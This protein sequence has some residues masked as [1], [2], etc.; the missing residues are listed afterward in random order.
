MAEPYYGEIR[1]FALGSY[2]PRNWAHCNGAILEISQND[3][4]F[5]VIGDMYGGNGRTTMALPNLQG[6]APMHPGTGPGLTPR[7]LTE[8]LGYPAIL[9]DE[10]NL[11][12]HT[13]QMVG[14][15]GDGTS[16]DPTNCLLGR[17]AE[18]LRDRLY[19]TNS[20]TNLYPM[21]KGVGQTG[22]DQAH[23]NMQPYLTLNFCIALDGAFPSR[24]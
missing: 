14:D 24:N 4:L 12:A 7:Y 13:H 16:N 20:S 17:E 19:A 9:L 2:A 18:I 23:Y 11:P 5:A 21:S 6:R 15:A 10:Y 1:M 3:I 22:G 8:F